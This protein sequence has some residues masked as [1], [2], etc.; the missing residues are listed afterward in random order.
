MKSVIPTLNFR[1]FIND[2]YVEHNIGNLYSIVSSTDSELFV[3]VDADNDNG[4]NITENE[5]FLIDND[6]KRELLYSKIDGYME[7]SQMEDSS[8]YE[9]PSIAGG[10]YNEL[11]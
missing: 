7:D 8:D 2:S 9:H 3:V 6:A 11:Y 5:H 1:R 4:W 10:I